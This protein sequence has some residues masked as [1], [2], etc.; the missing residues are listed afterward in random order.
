MIA[1]LQFY[2]KK[3]L[4]QLTPSFSGLFCR[5][6]DQRFFL[7]IITTQLLLML[8]IVLFLLFFLLNTSILRSIERTLNYTK[9]EVFYKAPHY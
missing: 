4:S 3:S 1:G 5:T 9:I 2:I 6:F 8:S 7:Q